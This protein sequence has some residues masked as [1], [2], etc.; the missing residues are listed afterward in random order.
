MKHPY[1]DLPLP[2]SIG[3]RGAAGHAPENTV[4]SFELALQQG[5]AIL[6]SDLHASADGE[7]IMLHDPLLERTSNHTGPCDKLDYRALQALDAGYHFK[8]NDGNFPFRNQDI[9]IPSLK[10]CLNSFPKARWNLEIKAK[11]QELLQS[12]FDIVEAAESEEHVLLAA[13]DHNI[14]QSLR[15]EAARRHSKI[16]IGTSS[17]EVVAFLKCMAEKKPPQAD[18]L[19]LQVPESFGSQTLVTQEFVDYA[20]EFDIQVHVW[21]V[22][23]AASM[24]ALLRRGVDGIITDYPDRLLQCIQQHKQG[25]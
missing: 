1:L 4:P 6:E 13:A 7:I 25:Q 5:A 21:T 17:S 14:M 18:L 23:E 15:L 20:H 9:Y 12:V 22:N 8:D 19:A 11:G 3:H 24:E 16:A 2:I 10:E